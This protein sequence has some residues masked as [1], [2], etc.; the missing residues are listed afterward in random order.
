[1]SR[2]SLYVSLV[3]LVLVL[4]SLAVALGGDPWGPH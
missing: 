1:M 3:L 4:G 2:Y